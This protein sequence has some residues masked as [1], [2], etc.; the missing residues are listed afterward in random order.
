MIILSTEKSAHCE[1][2]ELSFIWGKLRTMGQETAFQIALRNHSKKVGG[3]S[4]L[5]MNLV[6]GGGMCSQVH[7]LAEA[8]CSSWGADVTINDFNAL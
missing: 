3:S 1:C 5:Y 8:C 2:C 7:I 6:K 4:V